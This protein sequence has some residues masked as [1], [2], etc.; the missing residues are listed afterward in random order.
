MLPTVSSE[1]LSDHSDKPSFSEA[2][3]QQMTEYCISCNQWAR[4][5]STE[6]SIKHQHESIGNRQTSISDWIEA[7]GKRA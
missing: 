6:I 7:K 2:F 3:R 1:N 5:S 4:N